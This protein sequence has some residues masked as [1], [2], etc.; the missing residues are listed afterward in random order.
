MKNINFVG[1]R[2]L[3]DFEIS[4]LEDLTG[5]FYSKVNRRFEDI[6]LTL[7]IKKYNATGKRKKYS[8]HLRADHPD[9]NNRVLSAKHFDWDL[10]T[11]LHKTFD[12]LLS[13]MDHKTEK[14]ASKIAKKR[15]KKTLIS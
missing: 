5:K 12:S 1:I 7:D 9:I 14:L 3:D 15:I 2:K 11:A 6:M 4:L 8:I 10:A 13:E